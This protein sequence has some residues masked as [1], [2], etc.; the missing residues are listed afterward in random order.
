M[1]S[2]EKTWV[3]WERTSESRMVRRAGV[4]R[5]RWSAWRAGQKLCTGPFEIKRE[6]APPDADGPS[7]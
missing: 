2:D 5:S 7:D 3:I 6:E 1:V 4:F